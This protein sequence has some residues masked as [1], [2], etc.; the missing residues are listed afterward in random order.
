MSASSVDGSLN[1]TCQLAV[2][3]QAYSS[4]RVMPWRVSATGRRSGSGA[5]GRSVKCD[6]GISRCGSRGVRHSHEDGLLQAEAS[7][8]TPGGQSHDLLIKQNET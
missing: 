4:V 3:I 7:H 1:I 8:P 6:M 5:A 2:R